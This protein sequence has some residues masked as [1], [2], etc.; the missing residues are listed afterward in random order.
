M[1]VRHNVRDYHK[2][3]MEGQEEVRGKKENESM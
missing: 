2:V 3:T 1:V